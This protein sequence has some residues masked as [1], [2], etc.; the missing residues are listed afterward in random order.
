[1]KSELTT[2]LAKE[3]AIE[4]AQA[5]IDIG[6]RAGVDALHPLYRSQV[7]TSFTSWNILDLYDHKEIRLAAIRAIED[8]SSVNSSTGR[9]VGGSSSHHHACEARIA[10]FFG[11]ESGLLFL[12]RTQAILTL[13]TA[14]SK[15]GTVVL[16]PAMSA[17]PVADACTLVELEYG[18][19]DGIE[20]L[21]QLL[22]RYRT[23]K[24]VIVIGE[25]VAATTG[26]RLD[27]M[28]FFSVIEQFGAW[29]VLDESAAVA[30]TG[31]RGAGSA[32]LFPS[33]P[34]LLA[35][36]CS[37][38][39]IAGADIAA[40]VCSVELKDLLMQRSRYV[41][42]E[43]PPPSPLAAAVFS[44]IDLVELAVTQREKLLI[45]SKMVQNAIRAQ[46]WS[47]VSDDDAPIVALWFD[48]FA[49]AREVQEGLVQRGSVVEALTARGV[50]K[51]GA[52][53]R[54][55]LSSGHTDLEVSRLL[56][57]LL[58]IRKRLAS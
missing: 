12:S 20:E 16:G 50:R 38:N 48:T 58:E 6:I 56:D 25:V 44:G 39:A 28:L 26:K 42:V 54:A 32:E 36:L 5:P 15:D 57:G 27:P 14:I 37:C 33:S 35:R 9:Y 11:A 46:G 52:V 51:N 53:V 18:E 31:L 24:R 29:G 55:V 47:V 4:A 13:I 45:R 43:P 1:V 10:A 40:L 3:L 22:E 30:H 2:A 8:Q 23:A 49:K 41:R 17:L 19:F 34:A 7:V 21:R